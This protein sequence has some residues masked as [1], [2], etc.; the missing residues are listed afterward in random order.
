MT[1][2]SLGL[3]L[4]NYIAYK[5]K[6]QLMPG[7]QMILKAGTYGVICFGKTVLCYGI[8]SGFLPESNLVGAKD[9]MSLFCKTIGYLLFLLFIQLFFEN[10]R[11]LQRFRGGHLLL[12]PPPSPLQKASEFRGII[13]EPV[14]CGQSH[15]VI[16]P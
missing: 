15:S 5:R 10:F 3:E 12:P 7:F 16:R 4:F 13:H 11:W 1:S 14:V 9:N 6:Y 2:V 8:E